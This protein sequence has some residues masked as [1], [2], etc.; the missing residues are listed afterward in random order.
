MEQNRFDIH[1]NSHS[2]QGL[3]VVQIATDTMKKCDVC[4][5]KPAPQ[6]LLQSNAQEF[7]LQTHN[8]VGSGTA[9]MTPIMVD[10]M[11]DM[12]PFAVYENYRY[13]F[14]I[15]SITE[16]QAWS[17][18]GYLIP[19]V[20]INSMPFQNCFHR[21]DL[22]LR[23]DGTLFLLAKGI[24]YEDEIGKMNPYLT[25]GTP[26]QRSLYGIGIVLYELLSTP[27]RF[28]NGD[29]RA[30]FQQKPT[31]IGN[32][33]TELSLDLVT[34]ID[35]LIH[36]NP[37]MR[38]SV[39]SKITATDAPIFPIPVK[40][41]QPKQQDISKHHTQNKPMVSNTTSFVPTQ[42]KPDL[43]LPP[44]LFVMT[45]NE[46]PDSIR[47]RVSALSEIDDDNLRECLL[48]PRHT[49][50]F[51]VQNE[52][53]LER[54]KAYFDE[55]GIPYVIQRK[56]SLSIPLFMGLLGVIIGFFTIYG[57]LLFLL[58]PVISYVLYQQ[59]AQY[60]TQWDELHRQQ[61]RPPHVQQ[62]LD[63]IQKTQR[64]VIKSSWGEL[65]KLDIYANLEELYTAVALKIEKKQDYTSEMAAEI[66]EICE[67]LENVALSQSDVEDEQDVLEKTKS[68]LKKLSKI[69]QM[70]QF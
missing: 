34:I 46:L 7:F 24:L 21:E 20:A 32:K 27:L 70:R 8:C 66:I 58:A 47:H 62:V 23:D 25:E 19:S 16:E 5:I 35:T 17:I 51:G 18:L 30:A 3:I 2:K 49:P 61:N 48:L 9:E 53:D 15:S 69:S 44:I 68:N 31:S 52:R 56:P 28:M 29:Q 60:K 63:A 43:E 6:I 41:K 37:E 13:P 59:H 1:E 11:V 64:E 22:C 14:E 42:A 65:G 55:I 40:Q 38:T 12:T 57:F 36:P 26:L 45:N 67:Q 39:L 33:N 54:Y 4:I 50:I 10:R